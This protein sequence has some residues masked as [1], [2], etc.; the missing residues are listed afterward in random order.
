MSDIAADARAQD[1]TDD[2]LRFAI[3]CDER[4]FAI[5]HSAARKTHDIVEKSQRPAKRVV[6]IIDERI[7]MAAIRCGNHGRRGLVVSLI[8]GPDLYLRRSRILWRAC[9]PHGQ[10]HE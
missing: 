2:A 8:P 7:D 10:H 3:E 1:Q 4:S 5:E 6:L 9:F